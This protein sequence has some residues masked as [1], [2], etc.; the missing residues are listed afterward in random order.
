[1]TIRY[2]IADAIF[3]SCI[4][5]LMYRELGLGIRIPYDGIIRLTKRVMAYARNG[6]GCK[7]V[8]CLLGVRTLGF[9][10]KTKKPTL[11]RMLLFRYV[12][13]EEMPC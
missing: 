5:Q 13:V 2:E 8:G 7:I 12:L 6:I 3:T 10:T 9:N 1:M 11:S 4:G